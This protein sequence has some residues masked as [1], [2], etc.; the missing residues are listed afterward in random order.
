MY[1]LFVLT[2][3]MHSQLH[4]LPSEATLLEAELTKAQIH[5]RVDI[6]DGKSIL[7]RAPENK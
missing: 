7:C 3:R 1:V 6:R 2:K 4:P 5:S